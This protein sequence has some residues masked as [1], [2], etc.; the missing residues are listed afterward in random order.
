MVWQVAIRNEVLLAE[1]AQAEQRAQPDAR[2]SR[3]SDRMAIIPAADAALAKSLLPER[4]DSSPS[5]RGADVLTEDGQ[6]AHMSVAKAGPIGS[7]CRTARRATT[8]RLI[9]RAPAVNHLSQTQVSTHVPFSQMFTARCEAP[10]G[11]TS[12]PNRAW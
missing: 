11:Q 10:F 9:P 12:G 6:P 1:A 3:K 7:L 2:F 5:L 4:A 8:T